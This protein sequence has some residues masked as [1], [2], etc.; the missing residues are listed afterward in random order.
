MNK[1]GYVEPHRVFVLNPDHQHSEVLATNAT[2]LT[3][4]VVGIRTGLTTRIRVSM[5][6][7]SLVFEDIIKELMHHRY[8]IMPNEAFELENYVIIGQI[9]PVNAPFI[10]EDKYISIL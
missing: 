5:T 2:T 6:D 8:V 3:L 4:E 9:I 1:L 7:A 10:F